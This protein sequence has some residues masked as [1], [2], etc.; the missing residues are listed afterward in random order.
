MIRKNTPA[1]TLFALTYFVLGFSVNACNPSQP[2]NEPDPEGFVRYTGNPV[3]NPR[4]LKSPTSGTFSVACTADP[5][6]L[7]DERAQ[8]WRVYWTFWDWYAEE[9]DQMAA[10]IFG[11]TSADGKNFVP[12]DTLA[13]EQ[14]GTFDTGSV[15]TC[16][17]VMVDDPENSGSKLYYMYYSASILDDHDEPCFHQVGLAISRDGERFTPLSAERSKDGIPGLLFSVGDVLG[18]IDDTENFI[19]DPTVVVVDGTFHM[20]TL[21]VELVPE[22]N[23]GICYHTSHDGISWSHHGVIS[24][25]NRACAI[26]PT[27]FRNPR[28]DRFEMYVVMD[29]PEEEA[30]IHDMATN[31]ELRVSAFYHAT[32]ID[33]LTWTESSS[34]P[35]FF[36]DTSYQSENRGLATGADAEYKDGVVYLYYPS[37]TTLGGSGFGTLL[38]W[39]L[40]LATMPLEK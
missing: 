2:R 30:E 9:H 8:K 34:D 21:C 11:A 38:N 6:A 33:G 3:I 5:C 17:V 36:E 26:Q 28:K 10:G 19:A 4:E 29:T 27:V 24:G 39:P 40:N 20:W 13:L 12:L 31:L 7:W 16:D 37:F 23:G 25:L 35:A 14:Q 32:S 15:E 18:G 22:P 1:A